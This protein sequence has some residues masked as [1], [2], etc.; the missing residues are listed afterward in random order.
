[1]NDSDSGVDSLT[2]IRDDTAVD[3][4]AA[5]TPETTEL[6]TV[7]PTENGAR[8][9]DAT[10]DSENEKKK[11]SWVV[12]LLV[13]LG[14]VA[15]IAAVAGFLLMNSTKNDGRERAASRGGEQQA[16]WKIRSFPIGGKKSD[17]PAAA[18]KS[19]GTLITRWSNAVYL[20]PGEIKSVTQR[21]FTKEAAA[22]FR[23]SDIG[24]P[25]NAK[26]IETQRRS[27]RIGI[28]VDGAK[29]AAA[30]VEVVA[31][32]TTGKEDFRSM[33][34]SR[35]WLEREG[36]TWRVIAFDIDQEPLPLHP[37]KGGKGKSKDSQGKPAADK[38]KDDVTSSTKGGDK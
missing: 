20:Y 12:P 24:L 28:D 3:D 11:S 26:E 27:A 34:D 23:A 38:G 5:V 18:E 17:L 31:T 4:E 9:Q 10:D 8:P 14:V 37:N 6:Q 16:E 32:G 22:A 35:L 1:M 2:D 33:T 19:L 13:G 7:E 29:R 30:H 36:S 15:L 21:Y 25:N